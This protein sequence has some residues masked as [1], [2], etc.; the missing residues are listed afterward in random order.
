MPGGRAPDGQL[1]AARRRVAAAPD[2][3]DARLALGGLHSFQRVGDRAAY[4]GAL[5]VATEMPVLS[6]WVHFPVVGLAVEVAPPP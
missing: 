5:A 2:D 6:L 1:E 3:V 4:A